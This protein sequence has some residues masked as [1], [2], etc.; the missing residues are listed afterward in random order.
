MLWNEPNINLFFV[1]RML[2]PLMS[3]IF[4][5]FPKNSYIMYFFYLCLLL[6][7]NIHQILVIPSFDIQARV[8]CPRK[9][10]LNSSWITKTQFVTR[11]AE[12]YLGGTWAAPICAI[13]QESFHQNNV[14]S[15]P[16]KWKFC[17]FINSRNKECFYCIKGNGFR[18]LYFIYKLH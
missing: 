3:I 14:L 12:I 9:L 1:G 8:Y 5:H 15:L 18:L 13:K 4:T 7:S 10:S 16:P 6:P 11:Q 2:F 17:L